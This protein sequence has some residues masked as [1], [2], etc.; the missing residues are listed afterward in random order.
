PGRFLAARFDKQS[1]DV[2]EEV[3]AAAVKPRAADI[4][5][6]DRIEAGAKGAGV[7]RRDDGAIG[8]H[9]EVR[10]MN[11]EQRREEQLFGVLEILIEDVLDVFGCKRH[12]AKYNV[13]APAD[14]QVGR[15]RVLVGADLCVRPMP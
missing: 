12:R 1:I 14:T 10:V 13:A 2:E 3:L 7:G 15:Y 9:D 4:R 11:R 5:G 6:G 8:K